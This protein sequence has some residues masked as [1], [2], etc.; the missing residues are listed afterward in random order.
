MDF[1]QFRTDFS[2]AKRQK[3][4]GNVSARE[5][6]NGIVS[7]LISKM[8]AL[9]RDGQPYARADIELTNR[10]QALATWEDDGN[11]YIKLFPGVTEMLASTKIDIDCQFV[12]FPFQSFEIRFPMTNNPMVE[13]PK[14]PLRS[15][16]VSSLAAVKGKYGHQMTGLEAPVISDERQVVLWLDFGETHSTMGI[17]GE[18]VFFFLNLHLAHGKT[19]QQILDVAH[20][21]GIGAPGY[22]PSPA[23]CRSATAIAIATTFFLNNEHELVAPDIHRRFVERWRNAK[24][25]NDKKEIKTVLHQSRKLGHGGWKVGEEIELPKPQVVYHEKPQGNTSSVSGWELHFSHVRSSHMRLQWYGSGENRRAEL[26]LIKPTVVRPDLPPRRGF[27]I[28][29]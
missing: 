15:M 10:C 16:L 6:Y 2:H 17:N 20:Q 7:S 12:K 22:V 24:K 18:P 4:A 25:R 13:D 5:Y 28:K 11:P 8:T 1:Y 27:V 14:W 26:I 29:G 19:V 9:E 3:L 23:F 21:K